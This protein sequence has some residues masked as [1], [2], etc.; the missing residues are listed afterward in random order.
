[1]SSKTLPDQGQFLIHSAQLKPDDHSIAVDSARGSSM[2]GIGYLCPSS[3][4]LFLDLIVVFVF[5]FVFV[6]V[7]AFPLNPVF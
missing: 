2:C 4:D 1:M 7:P 6:F 3:S 5:V